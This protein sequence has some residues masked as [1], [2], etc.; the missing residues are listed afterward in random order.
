MTRKELNSYDHILIAFSGGKDSLACLLHILEM[1]ADKNKIELWHHLIDGREG[2]KLMDWPVTEDYCRKVGQAFNIPVYY[3]W[4]VGG[5]EREMNRNN[6]ATA[7]TKFE[8]P[9]E[10]NIIECGMSGGKGPAGTRQKFPQV[11]ADLK[12]RWCSAYLKIDVCTSAMVNQE[13]FK[14]G[15]ILLVTGERAEES[16]ARSKYKTIQP[17]KATSKKRTVN[18]WRPVHAWTEIQ[19]WEIIQ[20]AGVKSHP[21][22]V[23]GWGRLSCMKCIFGSDNQW[24]SAYTIDPQGTS[25]V[26]EYEEKFELTIHRKL[27]VKERICRGSSYKAI[28]DPEYQAEL[29]AAMS[30]VYNLEVLHAHPLEWKLP[31]GAFGESN[32]PS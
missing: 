16:T 8:M 13:R 29:K 9:A 26:M 4:K 12:V 20:R 10:E 17:H 3:S 5:F 7:P 32:G 28:Q 24:S 21:A 30:E 1:G 11:S 6:T 14:E 2:S 15:K 27:S 23:L 22:Y 25:K 19:V 31:A 18:Q